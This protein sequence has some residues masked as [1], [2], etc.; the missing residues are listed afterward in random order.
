MKPTSTTWVTAAFLQ[1]WDQRLSCRCLSACLMAS[2]LVGWGDRPSLRGRS[3]MMNHSW[4]Q[5]RPK[6]SSSKTRIKAIENKRLKSLVLHLP[7]ESHST[8]VSIILMI[9]ILISISNSRSESC[10]PPPKSSRASWTQRCKPHLSNLKSRL[11]NWHHHSREESTQQ[12]D[13]VWSN[14]TKWMESSD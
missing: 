5:L 7:Q 10:P 1:I 12:R 14:N 8:V 9:G 4:F 13:H 2:C 3:R 11:P 6:S